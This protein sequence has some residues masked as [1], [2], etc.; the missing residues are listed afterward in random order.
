MHFAFQPLFL[1]DWFAVTLCKPIDFGSSVAQIIRTT[2]TDDAIVVRSFAS[3]TS[4]RDCF[5]S[6]KPAASVD[7]DIRGDFLNR[8]SAESQCR[9]YGVY[10]RP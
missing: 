3:R 2:V 6:E 5:D 4:G 7:F 10:C 9:R 1:R 8:D